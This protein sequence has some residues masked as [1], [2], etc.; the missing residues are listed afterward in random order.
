MTFTDFWYS[1]SP[2]EKK[3][4]VV[5]AETSYEQLLHLAS[6]RRSAGIVL[7]TKLCNADRRIGAEMLRPDLFPPGYDLENLRG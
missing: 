2:D 3:E 6:G 5:K 7:F 1:L 4:L